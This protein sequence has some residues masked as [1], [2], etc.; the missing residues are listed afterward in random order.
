MCVVQ[1]PQFQLSEGNKFVNHI[2]KLKSYCCHGQLA[3]FPVRTFLWASFGR[4]S[5]VM[6]GNAQPLIKTQLPLETRKVA[7]DQTVIL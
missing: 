4:F 1:I 2:L 5:P 7:H 6:V 3:V